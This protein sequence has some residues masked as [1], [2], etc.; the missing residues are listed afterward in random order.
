MQ[1]Y[2][3]VGGNPIT[4]Y[5]GTTT[6]TGLRIVGVTESIKEAKKIQEDNYDECGGLIITIVDGKEIVG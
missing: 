2:T 3:I 4:I 1:K 5:S 6:F